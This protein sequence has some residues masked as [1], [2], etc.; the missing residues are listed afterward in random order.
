MQTTKIFIIK[1][2]QIECNHLSIK[3]FFIRAN[4]SDIFISDLFVF[5]L[6][7]K[8]EKIKHIPIIKYLTVT[9]RIDLNYFSQILGTKQLHLDLSKIRQFEFFGE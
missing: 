2:V 9:F 3:C 7:K 1:I 8:V 6:N 4:A 5:F